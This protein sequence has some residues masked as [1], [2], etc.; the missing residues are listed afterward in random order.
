[1]TGP[2]TNEALMFLP[3]T[4]TAVLKNHVTLEVESIDGMYLNVYVP[5]LQTDAGVACFWRFHRGHRFASS[6]LMEP[7]SC[8]G[9]GF[10]DSLRG[11][12]NP[13]AISSPSEAFKW[14]CSLLAAMPDFCGRDWL[15]SQGRI[16]RHVVRYAAPSIS[17]FA[18]LIS[19]STMQNWLLKLDSLL[20]DSLEQGI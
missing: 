3:R 8:G 14:R 9:C 2:T 10:M 5:G 7:M 12:R 17:S 1:M 11:S 13:I 6:V 19:L 15:R 4:V 16:G 20:I 18:T